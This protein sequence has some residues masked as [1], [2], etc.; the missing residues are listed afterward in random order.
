MKVLVCGGRKYR[1]E[2]FLFRVLDQIH[3]DGTVIT[4]IIE[5]EAPGADLL[6]AKWAS[7]RS[8]HIEPYPALWN[9]HGLSAGPIR[10]RQM[11]IEGKPDLVVAFP[12]GEGTKNMVT[13]AKAAKV[14]VIE[15]V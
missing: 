11:L 13:Q 4:T 7:R 14:K 12:G 2:D 6:A 3:N 5:G 10:N 8:V 15:V 9:R 1:D